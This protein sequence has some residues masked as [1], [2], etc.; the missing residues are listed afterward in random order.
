[1]APGG[2]SEETLDMEAGAEEG[3]PSGEREGVRELESVKV[4][5]GEEVGVGEGFEVA[6]WEPVMLGV[7][8]SM[9]E[10]EG[11]GVPLAVFVGA[12]GVAVTER[13]G[14]RGEVEGDADGLPVEDA[15][16]MDL[17]ETEGIEFEGVGVG[18]PPGALR[19]LG[20]RVG[21]GG[22][23]VGESLGKKVVN[24][25]SEVEIEP[26]EETLAPPA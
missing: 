25:V 17:G 6:E 4:E 22:E 26:P 9:E 1:M 16:R 20:V 21:R 8:V 18:E 13:V 11:E 19:G 5:I 10:R 15:T 2:E 3:E 23:G 12:L 7:R 24:G 14:R